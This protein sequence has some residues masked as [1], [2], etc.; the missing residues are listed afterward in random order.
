[1]TNRDIIMTTKR[2]SPEHKEKI[3]KGLEEAR[4]GLRPKPTEKDR[5]KWLKAGLKAHY[6]LTLEDYQK[7]LDKQENRCA[8][9]DREE[10]SISRYGTPKRLTVDHNHATGQIRG[11]LCDNC[12]RGIG[13]L[14]EDIRILE[15]AIEYLK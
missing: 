6:G 12:N 15:K 5:L 10:S 14:Q 3:S 7:M 9:C 11:L 4:L 8:I 1:M 13:H 2:G